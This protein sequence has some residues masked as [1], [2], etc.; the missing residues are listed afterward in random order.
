MVFRQSQ[1]KKGSRVGALINGNQS[2]IEIQESKYCGD[3]FSSGF[4]KSQSFSLNPQQAVDNGQDGRLQLRLLSNANRIKAHQLEISINGELSYSDS[5][6]GSQIILPEIYLGFDE[7]D[8]GINVEVRGLLNNDRYAIGGASLVFPRSFNFDGVSFAKVLLP[9]KSGARHLVLQELGAAEEVVLY[10]TEEQKRYTPAFTDNQWEVELASAP[11]ERNLILSGSIQSVSAVETVRFNNY[12]DLSANYLIITHPHLR[13]G[14]DPVGQYAAYRAN[15]YG[16]RYSTAIIDVQEL[17]EQFAYGQYHHPIAI[18]NGVHYLLRQG[19]EL[20]YCF[21]VGKGREYPEV[22]NAN[23]LEDA[24]AQHQLLVPSFGYPASDNLLLSFPGESIASVAHGRLAATQPEEVEIYLEKV[25]G[26]E[27]NRGN[28]Q[29]IDERAWVK[30]VV[31]LGGGTTDQEKNAIRASLEGMGQE[32]AGNGYGGDLRS[33]YKAGSGPLISSLSQS[34]FDAI[35]PGCG[36]ITFFGHSSPG[37]FDF[38]ID[39]PDNYNNP[40]KYPLMLSL[41]CYSG[42]VFIEGRSIAERFTFL[43]KKAAVA[44]GATRG[45]GFINVLSAFGRKLY[46][47]IGGE[48]Y[49]QELGKAIRSA[50]QEINSNDIRYSIL[51]EQ[52]LFHGDPAI[53]LPVMEGPDLV[54]DPATVRTEPAVVSAVRDSFD[55]IF[56]VLNIGRNGDYSFELEIEQEYPDGR[57]EVAWRR[58]VDQDSYRKGHTVELPINQQMVGQNVFYLRLDKADEVVETPSAG[59]LNNEFLRGNGSLGL[60]VYVIDNTARAIHPPNFSVVADFPPKLMASTTDAAAEER[61]YVIE[62][63][64]TPYYNSPIR[65][66]AILRQRGGVIE[67]VPA[68]LSALDSAAYFWRISPD[69][70][71]GSGYVWSEHTFTYVPGSTAKWWQAGYWQQ[72]LGAPEGVEVKRDRWK[73]VDRVIDIRIR[74][75]LFIDNDDRPGLNYNNDNFAGSVVP[76]SYLDEGIAV[77]VSHPFTASFW[78]NPPNPEL[79]EA[80]DYGVPTGGSRVFAFPTATFPQRQNLLTFLKEIVPDD[81]LVFL[82][83]IVKTSSSDYYPE[84]WE[85]DTLQLG[86]G[87]DLYSYLESMGATEV[88]SLKDRGSVPYIL[89]YKKGAGLI[90]ERIAASKE[91][92]VNI[93]FGIPRRFASGSYFSPK[94]G[95]GQDWQQ[96]YWTKEG[97]ED[98]AADMVKASL[99]G[100]TS[101]G[102][103]IL[104]ADTLSEGVTNLDTSYLDSIVYLQLEYEV[105]DDL[106]RTPVKLHRWSVD[107]QPLPEVAFDPSSDFFFQSDTL[108]QGRLLKVRTAY[109]YLNDLN[110]PDSLSINFVISTPQNDRIEQ[111]IQHD[112]ANDSG[113]PRYLEF[114]Y[115]T[116]ELYP[117]LY[118]LLANLNGPA[119]QP[120]HQFFNNYIRLPFVIERDNRN[121]IATVTFDGRRIIDGDIVKPKPEIVIQLKDE[122]P[123]LLLNDTDQ[124]SIN[125]IWPNGKNE[126]IYFTREDIDY[127]PAVSAQR[128]EARVIFRPDLTM[129]STYT[130]VVQSR[131]ASGNF[132]GDQSYRISFNVHHSRRVAQLLNYPNPFSTSTRFL[133]EITGMPPDEY[134]IRIMTPSGRVVREL[135]EYDLG[136]LRVGRHL[137]DGSWDGTDEFGDRLANGVYLYKLILPEDEFGEYEHTNLSSSLDPNFFKRGFGKLVILR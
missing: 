80:G 137:T 57:R 118:Q 106:E 127:Q 61:S 117:G 70:T 6:Y 52:F 9:G 50:L 65:R 125:L 86:A 132:A 81:Y 112:N 8:S 104:L 54:F 41:G 48:Y 67:W 38:N 72:Q 3:G 27:G 110:F 63:D 130:L 74:N 103:T 11:G 22:R 121:P 59:E 133:Y 18:R 108:Q 1:V 111:T 100:Y 17:Y 21:L 56:D 4:K 15:T 58:R 76:W 96:V 47:N 135:R 37:T 24:L 109:R 64:T 94:I 46:E 7:L 128:N 42:N 91:E 116:S 5:V 32:I 71:A 90:G 101:T 77:V 62:I 68:S 55:L 113:E 84:Q 131:D 129:D 134:I 95:P 26:L 40:D 36:I 75:Q 82:F 114:E 39:N 30:R 85:S 78:T 73:F 126:R 122:N 49:G 87:N 124:V 98:T 119:P 123:Y 66:R 45:Y 89:I 51:T 2:S 99:L 16:E 93:T 25:R 28:N 13:Q 34:I 97:G 69:S 12:A 105:S 120:E 79:F 107:Y 83:S 60:P 88:R 102:D 92:E 31:H 53:R 35:N 29:S 43:E 115:P 20:E 14:E 33:F 136:P 19:V 23:Q 10:D 44:F